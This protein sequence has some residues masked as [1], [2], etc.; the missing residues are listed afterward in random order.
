MLLALVVWLLVAAACTQGNGDTA[1][2]SG[3]ASTD[4]STEDAADEPPGTGRCNPVD[5][6][7]CLLPWPSDTL[8]RA[9]SSTV[10]G[11][12]VDLPADGMPS[13]AGGAPIDPTE[14]NRNDGFSPASIPQVVI[15]DLD[16]DASALPP[17][18]DIGASMDHG[19][20]LVLIDTETGERVPA[21]AEIDI[22]VTDAGRAP[23]RVVPARAL[24]EGHQHAVGL[25][26]LLRSNGEEVE[27]SKAMT[28]VLQDPD[29]DQANWLGALEDAHGSLDGL[30]VGWS[31]TVASAD[32]ITDRLRHMWNETTEGLGLDPSD[33]GLVEGSGA[34]EFTVDSSASDGPVKVVE[35]SFQM[36]KYL[37]G[38]GGPGEVL[39][40]ADDPDGLP[41]SDGTMEAPFT[42]VVPAA[43]TEQV[44]F[45]VYGHGLLGDRS[46]VLDIGTLGAAVG[47]GFC[48]LDWI[49]M[50]SDDI[51]TVLAEFGD[52]SLFRTQPDR[53]TQAH[54][55]FLLLGRLLAASDGF[56]TNEAFTGADGVSMIQPAAITFLGASQGGILGGPS[57][58]LSPDW[59]RAIFAV[60]GM[61]Y[62]LLLRRSVDF[63]EFLPVIAEA[64]PDG[65]DQALALELTEQLWDRSEN[66]GWARHLTADP[67]PEGGDA[68]TVMILEA[69][70]DHQVANVATEKLARTLGVPRMAPT[71]APDRSTDTEPFWGIPEIDDYPHD[72][73]ALVMWDFGT[74]A[75]P[76]ANTPPREGEDPHGKL[77]DVPE[78][79]AL[80]VAFAQHNGVVLDVCGPEPC[81][82]DE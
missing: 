42:C 43:P 16:P 47:V 1:S 44:P 37:T 68:S 33:S 46:E 10:T 12:R 61:G 80:V 64:Y 72:G 65:L 18:T 30:D 32:G 29:E 4:A 36:P 73:S 53:L 19:S 15:P 31:F 51:P 21:W 56:A 82:S 20:N 8:T 6:S 55:G 71:L 57:T 58:A 78:A 40:N 76:T 54:L 66:A 49:G 67:F 13:N 27:P 3:D 41:T 60:G 14:W 81:T 25:W 28:M 79:L 35:G 62:N 24:N 9:D 77:A 2:G 45:V 11:L 52:L 50:S 74:P 70:G 38:D 63:D 75:P 17:Q 23:L 7:H 39:D 22:S 26:N 69:F 48:A 59:S 5:E 34:P